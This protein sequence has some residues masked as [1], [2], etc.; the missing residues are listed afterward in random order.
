MMDWT[1]PY[2]RA[3]SVCAKSSSLNKSLVLY[4]LAQ[5]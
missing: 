2:A 1:L 4:A 5:A 3:T